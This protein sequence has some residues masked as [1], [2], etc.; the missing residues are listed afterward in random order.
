MI[1]FLYNKANS[2]CTMPIYDCM[3]MEKDGGLYMRLLIFSTCTE[4]GVGEK[5]IEK[6][7]LLTNMNSE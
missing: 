7:K 1:L 4:Y 6:N 5:A 3:R 2:P